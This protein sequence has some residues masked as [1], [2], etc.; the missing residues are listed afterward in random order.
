MR[1]S[2][3]FTTDLNRG[4]TKPVPGEDARNTGSLVQKK[5]GEVF[6]VGLAYTGL[7][8]ADT[9]TCDGMEI[10]GNWSAK[11]D[12]HGRPSVNECTDYQDNREHKNK[13]GPQPVLRLPGLFTLFLS[14]AKIV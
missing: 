5:H 11:M 13:H 10:S 7:Y 3:V 12:G 2:K 6:S 8:N 9:D 4:C 1:R 14:L